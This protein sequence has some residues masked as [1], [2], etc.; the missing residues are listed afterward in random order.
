V[1]GTVHA[2]GRWW[3]PHSLLTA[4]RAFSASGRGADGTLPWGH[5]GLELLRV[6][7]R[8]FESAE[9]GLRRDRHARRERAVTR[10]DG[11]QKQCF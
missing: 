9:V 2:A 3:D 10:A 7:D 6:C 8:G 1:Q 5:A 4:A 11:T